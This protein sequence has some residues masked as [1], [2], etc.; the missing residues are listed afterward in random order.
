MIEV[1][2]A[3]MRAENEYVGAPTGGLDQ[4]T[5]LFASTGHALLLDFGGGTVRSVRWRPERDDVVLLV[6]DTGVAH[7]LVD[8]GYAARRADC[9]RAAR[10]L[11]VGRLAEAGP[12]DLDAVDDAQL[13]RR[14]RHVVSESG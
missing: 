12:D 9:E 2:R 13:R 8:G 1:V 3:C 11:G 7:E 4:T 6:V 10:L 5:S 14:A